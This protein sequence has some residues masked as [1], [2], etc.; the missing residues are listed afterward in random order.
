[1]DENKNQRLAREITDF[2]KE[3]LK[4]HL[5]KSNITKSLLH[6]MLTSFIAL[7]LVSGGAEPNRGSW[8]AAE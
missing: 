3:R 7:A 2:C 5:V 8:W 4:F 6:T 1:M